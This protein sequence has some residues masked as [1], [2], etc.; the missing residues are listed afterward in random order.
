MCSVLFL[1][2]IGEETIKPQDVNEKSGRLE[3]INGVD[4]RLG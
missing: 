1:M 3:P 4:N 2:N